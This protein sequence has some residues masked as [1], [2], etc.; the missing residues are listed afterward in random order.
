MTYAI[1]CLLC[2]KV[3]NSRLVEFS[4]KKQKNKLLVTHTLSSIKKNL[5]G[6]FLFFSFLLSN[7]VNQQYQY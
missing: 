6:D 1:V 3:K 2:G 7:K 5:L 4:Y